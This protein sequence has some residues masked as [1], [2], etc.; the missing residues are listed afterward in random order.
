MT[1]KTSDTNDEIIEIIDCQ[2]E[3]QEELD[4]IDRKCND[5][6]ADKLKAKERPKDDYKHS[7]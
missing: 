4:I 6:V 1:Q 3:R 2:S 5:W 7:K